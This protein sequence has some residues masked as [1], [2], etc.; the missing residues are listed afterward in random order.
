MITKVIEYLVKQLV[1]NNLIEEVEKDKYLYSLECFIEGVF[2]T[3]SLLILSLAFGKLIPTIVFLI[4]FF[5]LRK[6]TG[7]FH[8]NTFGGCYVGTIVLYILIVMIARY[9]ENE[10]TLLTTFTICAN[11]CILLI[12]TVN[13]PNISMNKEELNAAKRSSRLLSILLLM[14]VGFLW[15][16][17]INI[18][19]IVYMCLAIVLCAVLLIIAKLLRQEVRKGEQD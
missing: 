2:T 9:V 8:L 16:T 4:C 13:H 5:S 7:E 12:G 18:E 3:G 19:I 6:R 10:Q 14:L 1:E 17:E 11:G 15:W